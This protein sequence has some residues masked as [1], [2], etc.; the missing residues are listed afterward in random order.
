MS[1]SPS[2]AAIPQTAPQNAVPPPSQALPFYYDEVPLGAAGQRIP[3]GTF[4][5]ARPAAD[6]AAAAKQAVE[7]EAQARELGRQQG[8]MEA[9]KR[10]DEQLL[11]ER[12][13]IAAATAKF[14]HDCAA[15]YR[16][17]EE[18]AVQL[19][20][21]IA[22]KILHREAQTDPLL[23]MGVVRVALDRIDGATEV[24]L[25]VH[26]QRAADWRRHLACAISAER[27]PEIVEDAAL[28]L[29]QCELRTSMG[30]A[31]LGVEV[32][33]KEIEKGLMDLLAARP[34]AG[35]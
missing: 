29:E 9:A 32:Q 24:K 18:E 21:A 5:G 28:P 26:P 27:L 25:A 16:R 20:L 11:R 30:T 17:I 19:S 33:L 22:R 13:A 23:L 15:Y 2:R 1:S 31:P 3:G 6:S 35:G 4:P 10:F 8:V 7:R 12:T 34:V 14:A